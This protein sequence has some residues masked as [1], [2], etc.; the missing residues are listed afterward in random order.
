MFFIGYF[1]Q[2]TRK[3]KLLSKLFLKLISERLEIL[4]FHSVFV[5]LYEDVKNN[6]YRKHNSTSNNS[7]TSKMKNLSIAH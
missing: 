6:I 1:F 5:V 2:S 7:C 3:V 4:Q